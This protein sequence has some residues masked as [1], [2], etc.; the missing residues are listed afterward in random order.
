MD[1]PCLPAACRP[2]ALLLNSH[3]PQPGQRKGNLTVNKALT[4]L[5][6][7]CPA[8]S[9]TDFSTFLKVCWRNTQK[10][11]PS[12]CKDLLGALPCS[13]HHSDS[14]ALRSRQNAGRSLLGVTHQQHYLCFCLSSIHQS[15]LIDSTTSSQLPKEITVSKLL[16]V[17]INGGGYF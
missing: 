4:L 8:C 17:S 14:T 12:I 16:S 11:S 2:S 7:H 6:G 1:A 10:S 3:L 5:Q 9:L 15:Q 13:A